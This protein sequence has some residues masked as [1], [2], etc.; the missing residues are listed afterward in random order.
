MQWH[1]W[2]FDLQEAA[3]EPVRQLAGRLHPCADIRRR[4]EDTLEE[5]APVQ[6]HKGNVIKPGISAELD[7]LRDIGQSGKNIWCAFN[8]GSSRD[9]HQQSEDRLQ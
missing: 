9:W 5:E 2:H 1:S 4:M 6:L 8:K 3:A 7:Q